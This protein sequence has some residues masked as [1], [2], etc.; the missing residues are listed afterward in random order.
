MNFDA[1]KTL[2]SQTIMYC[3][4]IERDIKLIYAYM[5]TGDLDENFRFIS[6]R[7]LGQAVILLKKLD[8]EDSKPNISASD[9]N[10]LMQMTEKRNYWRHSNYTDFMYIQDFIYSDEYRKVSE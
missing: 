1:F 8:N 3:Q 9:Y 7:T 6:K 2:H 10:F 4:I 5:H